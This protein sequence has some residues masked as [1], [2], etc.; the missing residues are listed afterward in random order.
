M[1]TNHTPDDFEAIYL[2]SFPALTAELEATIGA[3]PVF[4]PIFSRLGESERRAR[5]DAAR[6]RIC[7]ALRG[8]WAPYEESLR[9]DGA[10][11]AR[12]G[13]GFETWYEF[14]SAWLHVLTPILVERLAAHPARLSAA[15][16]TMHG[17]AGRATALMGG[18]YVAASESHVREREEDLAA[19]LQCATAGVIT[20]DARGVVTRANASARN[21]MGRPDEP[22]GQPL[23]DV[24]RARP[25]PN[26]PTGEAHVLESPE[27]EIPVLCTRAP[28]TR[29]DGATRGEVI[30]FRDIT[31]LRRRERDLARW[32]ALFERVSWGIAI[33]DE[34]G[35]NI[36]AANAAFVR[37][38]GLTLDQV[39]G[40]TM[41]PLFAPG[42]F[43]R[44][45]AAHRS[46]ARELGHA[47]YDAT[48]QRSDG[49][50]F[51][52]RLEAA[53]ISDAPEQPVW[54]ITVH[55]LTDRAE[56]ASLRAR[57]QELEI[58]NR[59]IQEANRLKSEFLANMSHELRTPL[60]SILGFSELLRDGAVGPLAEQ[61]AEFV[62]DIH[63]SG[64]HLLRL[65]N[66]ILDLSKVEAGR[67]DFQPATVDLRAL[68]DEVTRILGGL[69]VEK[70][71]RIEVS[72]AP[73][74][75]QVELDPQRLRQVLFNFLSNACKFSPPGATIGLRMV[76]VQSEGSGTFRIEVED[77]GPGI[78]KKDL[79]RLFTQFEQLD[80][81]ST[82]AH[83]G[84]G[85]GLALTRGLVEAQGGSVGVES[86]P[87]QGS[88]FWAVLPKRA[89]SRT[90][91]LTPRQP[92]GASAESLRSSPSRTRR[93]RSR[94]HRERAHPPRLRGRRGRHGRAG[95]TGARGARV[96]RGDA[97]SPAP[98]HLRSRFA[99][100]HPR[101]RRERARPGRDRVPRDGAVPH[102][103]RGAR[104][105]PQ[106]R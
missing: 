26:D 99:E 52:A 36:A 45:V 54:V 30:V 27:R 106:A 97:R 34:T 63:T 11:Y 39:V 56:V 91:L 51:P 73:E 19:T 66:D 71:L 5:A 76:D 6:D 38:Y 102:G 81:S 77:R 72:I 55:D 67:M 33:T 69:E 88:V 21:L 7:A 82:K 32:E 94:A 95:R 90:T 18:A 105:P 16:A 59:K 9:R 28:I 64:K 83:A 40:R 53:R 35:A 70:N 23:A 8:D 87:G 100:A 17:F 25:D 65:I 93:A 79:K 3:H 48:H 13:I 50:R 62:G 12:L 61:Q 4:G 101:E 85:L 47:S 41:E 1:T 58:E 104:R 84:T 49:T 20:T 103:V 10:A 43:E 60:N 22:V 78:A 86:A 46:R 57:G 24:F 98:G 2:D 74:I 14:T 75:G 89:A 42:E 37:M 29:S 96:R 68:T 15:L 31:V 80:A 44:V 92:S